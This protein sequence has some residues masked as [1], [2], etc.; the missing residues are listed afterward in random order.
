MKKVMYLVG[1]IGAFATTGGVT[2]KLLHL[3]GADQL[4]LIG[5]FTLLLI[6]VPLQAIDRYKVVLARAMSEKMKVVLGVL[7]A[8]AAGAA[9]IFKLMHLPG[10]D[11][12]LITGAIVFA[13]GFLPFF[14]FTM[15]KKAIS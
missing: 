4:F 8:L 5:F 1:F 12:L 15:Y 10:A 14:F 7:A 2:F 11:E 6:F 9:G 3:P 13:F